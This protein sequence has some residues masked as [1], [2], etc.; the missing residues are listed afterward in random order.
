MTTILLT[1]SP[2][3]RQNYYGDAALQALGELGEVRLNPGADPADPADLIRLAQGCQIIVSSRL[4]AA[5]AQVFDA[6][7][8]LVAFCRVAVDIRNID[9][10]AANRHGV[11][12]THATPGFAASVSEWIIGVM[13]D[14]ARGISQSAAA[15][16]RGDAPVIAMGRELRGA[17]LGII[18]HGHIGGY[19]APLAGALGMRVVISDP[20][21]EQ[22]PGDLPRLSLEALLAESDYVVCLAPANAR[23]AN[24]IDAAALRR[25]KR[26]AF[27]INASRGELVDED[28]LRAALDEGW[29]AG[30]AMDV[31]RAQ[32]QMPTPALA[33]HPRV[34]ATPHIGGLTPAASMHQAMDTVAQV[35]AI[36][37][38]E[39]PPHAVNLDNATRLR[40]LRA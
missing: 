20:K 29:I 12:V 18:G 31:G 17:T 22:D 39:A 34:I 15:Y 32:D 4:A 3:A 9:V 16:W 14:A 11:L 1:H 38:G 24:L 30:C 40:R 10:D 21:P 13:I 6:L 23:T 26:D 33:G 8:D 37:R 28:A 19:L 7:P 35:R 5:P 25:M 36:V 2:L 27:F